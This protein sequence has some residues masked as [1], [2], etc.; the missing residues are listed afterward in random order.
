MKPCQNRVVRAKGLADREREFGETTCRAEM[1][2]AMKGKDTVR[3]WYSSS[4][5]I[6]VLLKKYKHTHWQKASTEVLQ[7][8][9]AS[10]RPSILTKQGVCQSNTGTLYTPVITPPNN[11]LFSLSCVNGRIR[12][13]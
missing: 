13:D 1:R 12:R 3:L 2:G 7:T 4:V 11:T 10:Q 9:A 6:I 8:R 5:H